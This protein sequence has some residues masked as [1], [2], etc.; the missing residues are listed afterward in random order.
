MSCCTPTIKSF[1]NAL[2]TTIPYTATM[3]AQY[4]PTPEV[5][6][7]YWD[8]T[9]SRY[10]VN[11]LGSEVVFQANTITIDHGGISRGIVKI[12]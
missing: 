4:G 10:Y 1:F 6:V 5:E 11:Y 7:W 2:I 9:N 12:R 8:S 3:Q